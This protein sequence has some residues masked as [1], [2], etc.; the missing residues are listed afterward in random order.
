MSKTKHD[1]L[2]KYCNRVLE[3]KNRNGKEDERKCFEAL[4][5]GFNRIYNV[6]CFDID[7]TI[8]EK[9]STDPSDKIIVTLSRLVE[10]RIVTVFITG[11]GRTSSKEILEKLKIKIKDTKK[12]IN[13]RYFNRWYCITHN[14]VYLLH[15]SNGLFLNCED[16]I[17][18]ENKRKIAEE[19]HEIAINKKTQ[20]EEIF[21]DPAVNIQ[22]EPA[23]V[24]LMSEKKVN[25]KKVTNGLRNL[26]KLPKEVNVLIGIYGKGNIFEL[27]T[28]TKND[29][30][31]NAEKFLGIPRISMIRIGDQGQYGGNDFEMLKQ[32]NGF[33]VGDFS[34]NISGCFPVL[35]SNFNLIS[36]PSATARILDIVRTSTALSLKKVNH[37]TFPSKLMNIEK[38]STFRSTALL[39]KYSVL[40]SSWLDIDNPLFNINPY[41]FLLELFDGR[42]GAIKFRDWEWGLLD[43]DSIVKRV[44]NHKTNRDLGRT[45]IYALNTD[46]G[47]I[48]RGP[49]NYYYGILD[50][51]R[52]KNWAEK[53]VNKWLEFLRVVIK[54]LRTEIN[55]PEGFEYTTLANRKF[56]LGVLDNLRNMVIV[57]LNF[58]LVHLEVLNSVDFKIISMDSID[59][60]T[61]ALLD[62]SLK[63]SEHYYK[64]LF[65][66]SQPF[67][68]N[69][70]LKIVEDVEI[71]TSVLKNESR[72]KKGDKSP[73]NGDRE[74]DF[75][76]ENLI[77]VD[78]AFNKFSE[79]YSSFNKAIINIYSLLSGGIEMSILAK[80]LGDRMGLNVIPKFIYLPGNYQNRHGDLEKD[81]PNDFKTKSSIADDFN[82]IADDN[83][84]TGKTLQIGLDYLLSR[85]L[86]PDGII[87]GKSVV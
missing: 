42:S 67:D 30:I 58:R 79:T 27:S 60:K 3:L 34:K 16:F 86:D 32:Q 1:F 17:A 19:M 75:F 18:D 52:M 21:N 22:K 7:G 63:I 78:L 83:I 25:Q 8:C 41:T 36:G 29:A 31:R 4:E 39:R 35:D 64:A 26:I 56:I 71:Q 57:N 23:S 6:V 46:T 73:L 61:T 37:E 38:Y 53:Q 76:V 85:G 5:M 10:K 74:I 40:L 11:R 48:L 65:E 80:V 47:V 24:R 13:D 72:I 55:K 14:G 44:F 20:I 50:F 62:L 15:S 12:D 43:D 77:A 70:L 45:F 59:S 81:F 51:N 28:T 87:I 84:L 68:L 54:E 33:S 69:D 49:Y 9:G 82:I 2:V 66:G